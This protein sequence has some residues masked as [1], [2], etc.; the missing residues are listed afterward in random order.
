[1]EAF[2]VLATLKFNT[3]ADWPNSDQSIIGMEEKKLAYWSF[4][5]RGRPLYSGKGVLIERALLE[6]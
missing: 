1:M 2:I 3:L 4:G 5:Q 6:H